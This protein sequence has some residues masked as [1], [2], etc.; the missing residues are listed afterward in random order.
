VYSVVQYNDTALCFGGNFTK[1]SSVDC[2]NV[3]W[4]DLTSKSFIALPPVND[5]VKRLTVANGLLFAG[6]HFGSTSSANTSH[7]AV[8]V[9][10]SWKAVGKEA[11]NGDVE[12]FL[13]KDD[14]LYVGGW[15][16]QPF[17]YVAVWDLSLKI[18]KPAFPDIYYIPSSSQQQS[19]SVVYSLAWSPYFPDYLI[20]G[21]NFANLWGFG[22][23]N[24]AL[25]RPELKI[26]PNQD[27]YALRNDSYYYNTGVHGTVNAL[28]WFNNKMWIG[29]EFYGA[30]ISDYQYLC[31]WD[32]TLNNFTEIA[33][34]DS[35]V[36][37]FVRNYSEVIIGGA[38]SLVDQQP[39][40]GIIIWSQS[41]VRTLYGDEDVLGLNDEVTALALSPG[42]HVLYAAGDFT[43]ISQDQIK[44]LAK[45][46]VFAQ[47][48]FRLTNNSDSFYGVQ[49]LYWYRGWLWI[50][51]S[52]YFA[53]NSGGEYV[54]Y[55]IKY[56]GNKFYSTYKPSSSDSAS[57]INTIIAGP[58]YKLYVGGYFDTLNGTRLRHVGKYNYVSFEP[59]GSGVSDQIY[60]CDYFSNSLI[61]CGSFTT[62]GRVAA[63]SV[64]R[65]ENG[66]WYAVGSGVSSSAHTLAWS[67]KYLYVAGSFDSCRA[68][69]DCYNIARIPIVYENI[70][71]TPA[72][73][74]TQTPTQSVPTSSSTE[75][76]TET[77]TQPTETQ[78]STSV[79]TAPQ[80]TTP[81]TTQ[82][83]K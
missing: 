56:D 11:L 10:D 28:L 63:T 52:F 73:I 26:A 2:G 47:T 12:C 1:A 15:F 4:Y 22:A 60:Q 32:E 31:A 3:V 62:A 81:V 36:N 35:Y 74:P 48:W 40:D 39:C 57:R 6:G 37:V 79:P 83:R 30:G 76:P 69:L 44:Y 82:Y 33:T 8:Y 16:T 45:W 66:T 29:G 21:G 23:Q 53:L 20:I 50:G 13:V 34:V 25:Y 54:S 42:G 77:P 64:A 17:Q 18:W 14:Q 67:N 68:D 75:T 70:T 5:Y 59:L 58:D 46:D 9:N 72:Q 27:F 19:T 7:I 80:T 55:L 24:F 71:Y 43:Q 41:G 49:S 51:G 78:T 61:C 38:F 65:W